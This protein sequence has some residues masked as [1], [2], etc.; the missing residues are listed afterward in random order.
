MTSPSYSRKEARAALDSLNMGVPPAPEVTEYISVGLEKDLKV[1]E[2]EY[3]GPEGLLRESDQG[4]FKLVEAYYGGGK[5]HYLRAVERLAHR[6]GFA[7]AFVELHKNSCPLTRFDL[8]YARVIEALTLPVQGG[9]AKGIIDVLKC[10]V[11]VPEG[12]DADPLA[13]ADEQARAMGSL[14]FPSLAIALKLAAHAVASG[15]R[16]TQDELQVYLHGGKASPTLKK[17]GILESI[18]LKNG[19]L[20]LRSLI[21]WLRNIRL[22]GLVLI[23]D[24]GDRSL[25]YSAA[26]ERA[27]ASNNLVQLINETVK[28]GEWPGV[29]FLYSIPS[30]DDFESAFGSNQALIQRVRNSGFPNVPPAPRISLEARTASHT[31]KLAFCLEVGRRI[32]TLF[33]LAYPSSVSIKSS[34]AIA[35]LVAEVA[36]EQVVD[37]SFRRLFIKNFIACLYRARN[38]QEMTIRLVEQVFNDQGLED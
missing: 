34:E 37:V 23:M 2:S 15:D 14:P 1:F 9:F 36:L 5:T 27:Q 31:Q 20:A 22:P 32:A 6:H 33:Q 3:F 26:K 16:Q 25:S 13:Y 7:S 17:H 24:E 12:V 21:V 4:S 35:N 28:E 8:I 30:W 10:W 19:A 11:R 29:M 38:G 18:D